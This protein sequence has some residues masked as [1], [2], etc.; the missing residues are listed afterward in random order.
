[1]IRTHLWLGLVAL[2]LCSA[3]AQAQV[4]IGYTNIE[5]V[6]SL[7]PETQQINKELE[8]FEGKLQ[9]KQSYAQSKYEEY[10]TKTE[11]NLWNTPQEKTAAEEELK[12]LESEIRDFAQ[13][14]EN[15][16]VQKRQTLLSPVLEK[17]QTAINDVAKANGYTFVLNAGSSGSVSTVLFAPD[18]DNL[19][20][21]LLKHLNIEIPK[22][23]GTAGGTP[24][25]GGA[26]AGGGK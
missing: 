16:V 6:L 22:D 17:L 14:A 9:V 25:P 10:Q 2:V 8:T 21:R 7:M 4:K 3:T 24:A 1:M 20:E 5:I 26:P 12:K 23:P 15:Q 13:D 19:T 11:K 18:E